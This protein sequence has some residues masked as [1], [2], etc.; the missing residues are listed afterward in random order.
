MIEQKLEYT[1]EDAARALLQ[2]IPSSRWNAVTFAH[3]YAA[4]LE[5]KSD[6]ESARIIF[7]GKSHTLTRSKELVKKS[8]KDGFVM[9]LKIRKKTGS[10]ENPITKMFPGTLT[11]QRFLEKLD[12][13]V[14]SVN[15]LEYEDDRG[16]GH[17]L[18]DFTLNNGTHSLPLNIKT[19]GTRFEMAEKLVG[20]HPDDCIPIP[21]YKAH[22]AIEKAPELLYVVSVDYGLAGR[23]DS[24]LPDILNRDELITWDLLNKFAGTQVRNAE[25]LFIF[26][27]VHKYWDQLQ[28]IVERNPFHVISARKSIKVLQTKPY[29]T[30]GIGLKAW[31]T[32]AR[33]EINVHI[34]IEEDTTS[35]NEIHERIIENGLEDIIEAVNRKRWVFVHDPEI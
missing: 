23:I 22:G 14:N 13:L 20:L 1:D 32:G 17:T 7:D 11:E 29:R 15:D 31:G 33:S 19:H 18:T 3:G 5:G 2:V 21:A 16:S 35:W 27:M 10:A 34:S 9:S 26:E 4:M 24:E 30:P 28:R 6:E 8:K 12:D 25:D